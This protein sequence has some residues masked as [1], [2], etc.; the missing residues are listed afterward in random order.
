MSDNNQDSF[1]KFG[2]SFQEQ[3]GIL[4][5]RDRV[6]ADQM[7]EV[8]QPG[9]LEYEYLQEFTKE[10]FDYRNKYKVHPSEK[11][12]LSVLRSPGKNRDELLQQQ[13]I[14]YFV[15]NHKKD[16]EGG[17]W[18]KERSLDFCKKQ[19]LKEAILQSIDLMQTSSFDEISKLIN[20]ALLMG[21][22]SDFGLDYVADFEERFKMTTRN[23]VTTGSSVLDEVLRGGLGAGELGTVVGAS[24]AGKSFFLTMLGA[25]AVKAGKSVVHYTMELSSSEIARRYD[26]CI[27][28][29]PL[30]DHYQSKEE[31]FERI[32][33]LDGELLIKYYSAKAATTLTLRN[34]LEKLKQRGKE[35]DLILVDYADL[36]K[37][38]PNGHK[39]WRHD[40]DLETIYSELRN[41]GNDFLC[42]VYTASQGRRDTWNAEVFTPESIAASFAKIFVCDLVITLARTVDDKQNNR[43]RILVAKNR[44]GRDGQVY[45]LSMDTARASIEIL[46]EG[47]AGNLLDNPV[48]EQHKILQ[49]QYKKLK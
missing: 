22:S 44:N 8:L 46:P 18:I 47:E 12:L 40:Q 16:I 14:D 1:S 4:I 17:E 15:R 2:Q 48:G 7:C 37:P 6:F 28:G 21:T 41:L 49:E 11:M 42:P 24:G 26:S 29:V 43:A 10:I 39:D 20:E 38:I 25:A 19:V 35:I 34:H 9:F 45:P 33:D 5:L 32:R 30:N 23:P 36:L 3:L 13:L 31:I 27:T